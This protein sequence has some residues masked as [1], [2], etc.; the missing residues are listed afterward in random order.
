[1]ERKFKCVFYEGWGCHIQ[2]A[3][4]PLEVCKLCMQAREEYSKVIRRVERTEVREVG[5][6]EVRETLSRIDTLFIEGKLTVEEYLS[7]RR[8]LTSALEET[9]AARK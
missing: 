5:V 1:M 8:E 6:K 2:S 3:E 4:V 9:P 7:R